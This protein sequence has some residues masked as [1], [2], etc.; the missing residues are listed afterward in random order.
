MAGLL[1]GL[2]DAGLL[3]SVEAR[4]RLRSATLAVIR[5]A[6]DRALACA[7]ITVSRA[8]ANPPRLVELQER[9]AEHS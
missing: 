8:G 6:V 3:G 9:D 2:F 1:S 5:P 4:V 7:G